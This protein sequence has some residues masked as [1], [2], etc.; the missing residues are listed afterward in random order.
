[1]NAVI[2]PGKLK[3]TVAVPPSKSMAHR[4][5][6]C[7]AL[8][9]GTSRIHGIGNSDDIQAT[10]DCLN[11]LGMTSE[12]E[13]DVLTVSG[14]IIRNGNDVILPCRESASTMRFLLP[15][16][17]VM[18][19]RVTV[20]GSDR[21]MERGIGVYEDL[22][23]KNGIRATV[24][25]N[26]IRTEGRLKAGD[27][28]IPGN[29]SS[30]FASGLLIALS[31]CPGESTLT[32]LPPI[33]SRPYIDMTVSVLNKFGA[34]IRKDGTN[35]YRV[36]GTTVFHAVE[37]TAEGDWSAAAVFHTMNAMGHDISIS[38]TD[39]D[40][41]QGDKACLQDLKELANA[42]KVIDLTDTPDLGP[43]LFTASAAGHGGRFTGT[44]RLALK[45]S[46]RAEAMITELAKFGIHG[47]V[48]ENSV[49]IC[50]GTLHSPESPLNGHGDHRIVM[51]LTA[52]CSLTG[53]TIIGA[54]AVSKSY[55][56]FFDVM[57][58]LGMQIEFQ[59]TI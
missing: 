43:I 19:D 22:F 41:L 11:A 5:M 1:M 51:A 45:E 10:L 2:H 36:R 3:G 29:I 27:Y 23:R 21:L 12:W 37:S 20:N 24:D 34:E 9:E 28:G 26:G 7:A 54:E 15:L 31:V 33:E 48:G 30:Q 57:K 59:D 25:E 8:A 52:L 17:T 49:T 53:G 38:G 32:V 44:R 16:A 39:P 18:C 55:P 50:P 58:E 35:T 40:S 46:N 14:G 4:L 56:G 42:Q 6:I 13:N 47:T